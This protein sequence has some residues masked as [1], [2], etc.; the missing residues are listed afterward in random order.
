MAGRLRQEWESEERGKLREEVKQEIREEMMIEMS[1]QMRETLL[2]ELR[3]E[4]RVEAEQLEQESQEY[5]SSK[6]LEELR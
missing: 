1:G 5:L 6:V 3:D 2:K 4:L